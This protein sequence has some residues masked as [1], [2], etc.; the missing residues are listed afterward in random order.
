M[1]LSD[2]FSHRL[3]RTVLIVA[4]VDTVFRYF[5]DSA[6]WAAWWG[7][8]STIDARPGGHVRIS[9]AVVIASLGS[10]GA[11]AP[12]SKAVDWEKLFPEILGRYR[13]LVQIDTTAGRETLAVDCRRGI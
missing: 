10:L 5:T 4:D 3:D 6:R 7:A 8:G 11:Q 9:L 12:A 1:T 2:T 13:S